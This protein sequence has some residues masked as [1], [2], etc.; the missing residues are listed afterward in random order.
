MDRHKLYLAHLFY[1]AL[2]DL[3]PA[4]CLFGGLADLFGY[5]TCCGSDMLDT[6]IDLFHCLGIFQGAAGN[7]GAAFANLLN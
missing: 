6:D 1:G 5:F 2:G 3:V 4:G 7:R